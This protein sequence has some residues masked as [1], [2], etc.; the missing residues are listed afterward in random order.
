VDG[1]I[2]FLRDYIKQA[3]DKRSLYLRIMPR[4]EVRGALRFLDKNN[5]T[6]IKEATNS[7][8]S[9]ALSEYH[10]SKAY[11]GQFE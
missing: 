1:R 6:E 2:R 3:A 11:Y 8:F 4:T 9:T 10:V 5:Q 7:F